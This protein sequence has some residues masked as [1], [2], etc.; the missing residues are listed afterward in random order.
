MTRS[1]SL[2]WKASVNFVIVSLICVESMIP[3]EGSLLAGERDSVPVPDAKAMLRELRN[4]AMWAGSFRRCLGVRTV[5]TLAY[6]PTSVAMGTTHRGC[7]V[8]C[9]AVRK[10]GQARRP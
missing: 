2:A 10:P 3:P 4:F 6:Y 7:Q 9:Q 8:P 5:H 1:R